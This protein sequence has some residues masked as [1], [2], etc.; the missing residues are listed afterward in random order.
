MARYPSFVSLDRFVD[1]EWLR[2]LDGFIASCIRSHI[3]AGKDSFFLN[4]HRMD[5]RSPYQPGVRE[6]WLSKLIAGT[7]YN[8][9]DLDRPE[10]WEPSPAAAEFSPL[11]EFLGTLPFA[12]TARMIIIYDDQGNAVPAHRDHV[13]RE[14]CNEF[15]WMRTNFDKRF[16]VLNPDSGEKLYVNSHTAWF[17]TVNQ[18]HG[19]EASDGLTFSIRVDGVFSDEFRRQIPFPA[20]NRS[21]AP[22]LWAE[23]MAQAGAAMAQ[24]EMVG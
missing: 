3:A 18:Y 9:L 16:F 5:D 6:I 10:V 24:S 2:S 22:A 11:T 23:A 13:E 12:S 17:D 19:A 8:Y 1:V 14:V 21:S 7:P 20:S 4:Q 15:I